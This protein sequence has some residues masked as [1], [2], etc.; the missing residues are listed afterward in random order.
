MRLTIGGR[1]RLYRGWAG[2]CGDGLT[3]ALS[4]G[5][6]AGSPRRAAAI[7]PAGAGTPRPG[8]AGAAKTPT[9]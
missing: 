5:G 7:A 3:T 9:Q 8:V 6:V 4:T 2:D 1:C